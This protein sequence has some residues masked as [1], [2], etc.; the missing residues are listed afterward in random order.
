MMEKFED[1]KYSFKNT[2]DNFCKN[3]KDKVGV[4]IDSEQLEPYEQTLNI[5]INIE[6]K[7]E[8]ET[9]N[10]DRLLVESR[11]ILPRM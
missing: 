6:K 11:A 1:I 7:I 8:F 10:I 9:L 5:M 4:S 3:V 2:R